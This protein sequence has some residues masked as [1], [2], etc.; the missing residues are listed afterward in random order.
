[1]LDSITIEQW[2]EWRYMMS[3]YPYLFDNGNYFNAVNIA[4]NV[5]VMGNKAKPKDFYVAR[6]KPQTDQEIMDKLMAL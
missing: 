3:E 5:N 4:A 6:K 1:M 2:N